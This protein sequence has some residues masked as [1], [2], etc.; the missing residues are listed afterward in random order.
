MSKDNLATLRLDLTPKLN[1]PLSPWNFCDYIRLLFWIFYFPKALSWYLERFQKDKKSSS[2]LGNNS[3]PKL[4]DLS[5]SD[6][7]F[8]TNYS[9]PFIEQILAIWALILASIAVGLAIQ[10]FSLNSNFAENTIILFLFILALG[11]MPG[12]SAEMIFS[13]SSGRKES[14]F[15]GFIIAI[16]SG[17]LIL[18]TYGIVIFLLSLVSLFVAILPQLLISRHFIGNLV[19]NNNLTHLSI[20]SGAWLGLFF[21][22]FLNV[23]RV[24][25]KNASSQVFSGIGKDLS[26]CFFIYFIL[27]LSA[28]SEEIGGAGLSDQSLFSKV[29]FT[30]ILS[31]IGAIFFC[32]FFITSRLRMDCWILGFIFFSL[33]G[34]LPGNSSVIKISLSTFLGFPK[35]NKYLEDAIKR[36]WRS[37]FSLA[38]HVN[39]FSN[40]FHSI[41]YVLAKRISDAPDDQK[42]EKLINCVEVLDLANS[43]PERFFLPTYFCLSPKKKLVLEF[44]HRSILSFLISPPFRLSFFLSSPTCIISDGFSYLYKGQS[45][46][47]AQA[48]AFV[49]DIRHGEEMHGLASLL[50]LFDAA[51]TA[52]QIAAIDLPDLPPDRTLRPQTWAAIHRFYHVIS[53]TKTAQASASRTACAFA[54]NRALGEMQ[55]IIDHPGDLPEAERSLVIEIAKTWRNALLDITAAVGEI[56][57]T[58]PVQ[59]PYVIGDPVEGALFVGRDDIMRQLQELW[60]L[61]NHL[62]SVV[63]YGH[64]RMGKTSILKNIEPRL[65]SGIHVAY[66]NLLKSAGAETLSDVLLAISDQVAATLAIA[67]PSDAEMEASPDRTFDRFLR[68]ATDSLTKG[69]GLIIALDEFEKIEELIDGGKLEASFM[70]YL[71][72]LVQD[73]PKVGFAFAGLHTL[74]EMSADYFQPFFASVIPIKVDFFKRATVQTLLPNPGGDFPLDYD[75]DALDRIWELAAGQPYLTQ[76]IGFQ[77]VRRYNDLVFEQQQ[78]REAKFTVADV[79]AVIDQPEFFAQ[80]KPYFAGVWAQ[81]NHDAPG[82]QAILKALAIYPDGLELNNLHAAVGLDSATFSAALATL[83]NHDVVRLNDGNVQIIVEVFRRWVSDHHRD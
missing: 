63:I 13:A 5:F 51:E 55:H 62:Q 70:A 44:S 42:I 41:V 75:Y 22:T 67:P 60:L 6:F 29:L 37:G 14:F 47:A 79:Q 46:E 74:E 27:L 33:V 38:K 82:Q 66:V 26:V 36:E 20:F 7:R 81:A 71:R 69:K 58:Q 16:I 61:G 25:S 35:F 68:R 50:A 78:K 72:G 19:F 65:G 56:N 64:R 1:R 49:R 43:C 34:K 12:L 21:S 40:Q 10:V 17:S 83:Q 45:V 11:L 80:G 3:F 4:L 59:N 73:S 32:L 31:I 76:L 57:L 23:G 24:P 53:D 8:T 54:T 28:V 18:L 52:E 30:I 9:S 48:F 39:Y 15:G 77:L 2:R